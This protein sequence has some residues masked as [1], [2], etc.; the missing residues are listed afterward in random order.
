MS[1]P[2]MHESQ[3][4]AVDLPGRKLSWLV[5]NQ[6]LPRRITAQSA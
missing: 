2:V 6:Q 4:P 1:V 5:G 3:A